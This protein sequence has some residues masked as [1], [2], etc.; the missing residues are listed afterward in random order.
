MLWPTELNRPCDYK[1]QSHGGY[2][3]IITDAEGDEEMDLNSQE[4]WEQVGHVRRLHPSTRFG[5]IV[6]NGFGTL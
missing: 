3:G 6:T 1:V 5:A 4:R 2:F